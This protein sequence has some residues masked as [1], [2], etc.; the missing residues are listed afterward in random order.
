MSWRDPVGWML[1]KDVGEG[2][3]EVPPKPRNWPFGT[4]FTVGRLGARFS[5]EGRPN[6][7]ITLKNLKFWLWKC[8]VEMSG[9]GSL[10]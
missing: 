8:C 9:R 3:S 7:E 4:R 10:L 5:G 6:A 2:N 1:V